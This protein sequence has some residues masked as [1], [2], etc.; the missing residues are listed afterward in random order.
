MDGQT[1]TETVSFNESPISTFV[2]TYSMALYNR[3]IKVHYFINTGH[4]NDN[5]TQ[6]NKLKKS[7][8]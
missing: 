3:T 5:Q 2:S 7:I 8:V 4:M 6:Q 1:E